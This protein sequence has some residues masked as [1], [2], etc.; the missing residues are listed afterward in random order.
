MS[1]HNLAGFRRRS[2][3]RVRALGAQLRDYR[4][5]TAYLF[6]TPF[7]LYFLAFVLLPIVGSI[8]LSFAKWNVLEAPE[9]VGLRNYKRMLDDP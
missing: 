2:G 1:V 9:I 6:I 3:Q 8:V 4:V 5:R 7:M